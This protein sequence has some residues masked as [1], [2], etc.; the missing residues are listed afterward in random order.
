MAN[1]ELGD[2]L[3]ARRSGLRPE[4]VGMTAY[5]VRRVAGLRREEVAVLAGMNA[6]YY[7]SLEAGARTP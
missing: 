4:D 1:N 3:R 2:L 7:T 6:D 5:G